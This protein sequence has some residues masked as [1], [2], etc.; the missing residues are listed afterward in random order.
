MYDSVLSFPA[1]IDGG[2]NSWTDYNYEVNDMFIEGIPSDVRMLL[3]IA[4]SCSVQPLL[5]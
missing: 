4:Q 2:K 3:W 5:D 1:I